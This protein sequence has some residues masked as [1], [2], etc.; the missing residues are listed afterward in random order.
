MLR[1]LC[2]GEPGSGVFTATPIYPPFLTAPEFANRRLV[3]APLVLEENC[4][5]WHWPA[6]EAALTPDTRLFMLCN[7]HNPVGRAWRRDELARIGELALR[8]D[9][10]ICSDEIH[11]GLVLE[12]GVEHLPIAALDDAVAQRTITL[13]APSKT[14]NIAGLYCAFAIIPDATLRRR[15]CHEMRGIL[16]P[17]SLPGMVAAEAAYR[18]GEPWRLALIDTLRANRD[19]TL[20]TL[21]A[22]PGLSAA[23]VEATHLAWI[24]CRAAGLKQPAAFFEQHGVGLTDGAAFGAPGFVR[25]NFACPKSRLQE[26]L[27]RMAHALKSRPHAA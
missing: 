6:V 26:A 16:P 15:F 10:L 2:S 23:P 13:M 3:T 27:S 21:N 17:V 22:L 18:H 4:W 24:D 12:P 1:P 19:L 11:C 8:H 20:Q 7:P 14:F 5:Q 9:L 25:L